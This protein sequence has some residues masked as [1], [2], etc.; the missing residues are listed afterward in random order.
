MFGFNPNKIKRSPNTENS[1]KE[2]LEDKETKKEK[3]FLEING[4]KIE[5]EKYYFEYPK[6]VQEE[7]GILGYERVKISIENLDNFS[8]FLFEKEKG[9]SLNEIGIENFSQLDKILEKKY[10]YLNEKELEIIDKI[11]LFEES[12]C[13][14]LLDCLSDN[15]Y[16][17]FCHNHKFAYWSDRKTSERYIKNLKKDFFVS[18]IYDLEKVKKEKEYSLYPFSNA[19]KTSGDYS[20]THSNITIYDSKQPDK[21]IS[22]GNCVP[23]ANVIEF[24]GKIKSGEAY[25]CTTFSGLNLC[26]S[27]FFDGLEIKNIGFGFSYKLD[28]FMREYFEESLCVFNKQSLDINL[29]EKS[30]IEEIGASLILDDLISGKKNR[31]VYGNEMQQSLFIKRAERFYELG[32]GSRQFSHKHSYLPIFIGHPEIPQLSWGHAKYA[33]YFNEK[34]FNFFKFKHADHLPKPKDFKESKKEGE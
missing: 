27:N 32:A 1:E 11:G 3:F 25:A 24:E 28:S 10:E 34:G 6:H 22:T 29:I 23:I 12:F 30:S 2:K 17:Q 5:G 4:Q 7:T 20:S 14:K 19:K 13:Y 15:E 18:K 9:F 8:K 26:P 33:H 31:G 21:I 16:P